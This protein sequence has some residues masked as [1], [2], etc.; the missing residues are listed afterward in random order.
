[1][2]VLYHYSVSCQVFQNIPFVSYSVYRSEAVSKW[3]PCS[4]ARNKIKPAEIYISVSRIKVL[5]YGHIFYN[6]VTRRFLDL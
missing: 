3:L 6:N 2:T 5:R 1:M 4:C